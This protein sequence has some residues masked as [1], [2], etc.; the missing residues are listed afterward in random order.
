MMMIIISSRL[1]LQS[2]IN[3]HLFSYF[4]KYTKQNVNL[5][6]SSLQFVLP[7]QQDGC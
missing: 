2:H 3:E 6:Q 5:V 4:P 1:S 7:Q